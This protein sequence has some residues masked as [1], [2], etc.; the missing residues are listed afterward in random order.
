MQKNKIQ[1]L[2]EDYFSLYSPSLSKG[3]ALL[4]I[5]LEPELK[6]GELDLVFNLL[7]SEIAPYLQENS[8]TEEKA[9]I[10]RL[11]LFDK[12]KFK[13]E[14]LTD[15][16][17]LSLKQVIRTRKST[18]MFMGVL[19]MLLAENF[20]I[21]TF[22]ALSKGQ[23]FVCFRR[24]YNY[25]NV[26]IDMSNS[27]TFSTEKEHYLF[28]GAVDKSYGNFQILTVKQIIRHLLSN[29]IYLYTKQNADD[30]K[31]QVQTF[32]EKYL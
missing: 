16:K 3:V 32:L 5:F 20:N 14:P 28:V 10:F 23:V 31:Q 11:V 26:Y 12:L 2:F 21:P 4:T 17:Q 6:R 27:G 24:E 30:K 25:P 15:E 19:Y 7:A 1:Q 9:E 13:I 29:L 8:S 18:P 22:L